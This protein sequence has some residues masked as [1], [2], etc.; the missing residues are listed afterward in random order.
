MEVVTEGVV[1][2][3]MKAADGYEKPNDGSVVKGRCRYQCQVLF[4]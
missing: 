1:K 4:V 3:I 2:K